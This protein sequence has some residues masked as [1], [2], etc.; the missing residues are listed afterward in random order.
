MFAANTRLA[1]WLAPLL[2]TLLVVGVARVSALPSRWLAR[3]GDLSYG[4]Y[5]YAFP[6]QQ[7]V[8]ATGFAADYPR[9]AFAVAWLGTVGC[10]WLSWHLIEAPALR[11][12]PR[13]R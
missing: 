3:F 6:V 13:S 2:L 12:K 5:L 8:I 4:L 11:F 1:Y 9:R 10:A 7:A